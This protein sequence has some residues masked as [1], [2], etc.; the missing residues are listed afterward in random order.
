MVY[1]VTSADLSAT[2]TTLKILAPDATLTAD[3]KA[4][5]IVA[6]AR[7]A[8]HALIAGALERLQPDDPKSKPRVVACPGGDG[9]LGELKHFLEASRTG[10]APTVVTARDGLG[11]VEICEAEEKSVLER[12]IVPLS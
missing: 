3:S 10:V 2:I 1:P 6:W 12:R 11:S 4:G 9:Y 7:K 8:D 5:T